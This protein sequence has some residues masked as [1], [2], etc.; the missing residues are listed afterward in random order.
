MCRDGVS[1][2]ASDRVIGARARCAHCTLLRSLFPNGAHHSAADVEGVRHAVAGDLGGPGHVADPVRNARH[3]VP[4][5]RMICD[6]KVVAQQRFGHDGP[7]LGA[8]PVD[9]GFAFE[10]GGADCQFRV[11][12]GQRCPIRARAVGLESCYVLRHLAAVGDA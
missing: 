9:A 5:R 12:G 4:G 1:K 10:G 6:A 2:G 11:C 8:R 3:Q 7:R